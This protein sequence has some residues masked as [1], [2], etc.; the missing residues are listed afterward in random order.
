MHLVTYKSDQF[1]FKNWNTASLR[2]STLAK[3]QPQFYF[4][5][6]TR[7]TYLSAMRRTRDRCFDVSA[8]DYFTLQDVLLCC[9][10]F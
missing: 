6:F 10:L 2:T 1:I 5:F 8:L 3:I 4:Y 7:D 9:F